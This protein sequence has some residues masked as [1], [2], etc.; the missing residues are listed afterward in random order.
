M[1]KQTRASARYRQ[2]NVCAKAHSPEW[3]FFATSTLILGANKSGEVRFL[4]LAPDWHPQAFLVLIRRAIEHL[5]GMTRY[6]AHLCEHQARKNA[7]DL[8]CLPTRIGFRN[9]IPLKLLDRG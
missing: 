7:N 5:P 1:L 9:S 6:R 4:C 3:A 2:S 8:H